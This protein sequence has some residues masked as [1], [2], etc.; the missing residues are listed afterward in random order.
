MA[1]RKK[2]SA[3]RA[4]LIEAACDVFAE[5]GYDDATVAEICSRADANI[6][7]LNYHLGDKAAAYRMAYHLAFEEGLSR[8]PFD[9]QSDASPIERLEAHI[10]SLLRRMNVDGDLTRFERIRNWESLKP[11]GLVDDIDLEVRKE[12][13]AHMLK[14][15]DD[16]VGGG[17]SQN[18]LLLAEALVL[19]MCRMVLPF[20]RHELALVHDRKIDEDV[21]INLTRHI[22]D[23]L[24][25]GLKY[26]IARAS[27]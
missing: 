16:L 3:T 11:T 26:A 2:G 1:V 27:A 25:G 14:C 9:L 22:L 10:V 23:L 20:N 15:L 19:S 5:K 7:A 12:S 13:R 21:I 8:H 4:R 24:Q 17:A 18:E 6:A